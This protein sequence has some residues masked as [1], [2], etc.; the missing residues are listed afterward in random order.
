MRIR[1]LAVSAIAL[2][3]LAVTPVAASNS[4]ASVASSAAQAAAAPSAVPSQQ[5]DGTRG[6]RGSSGQFQQQTAS[7]TGKIHRTVQLAAGP[8]VNTYL[9][10]FVD[11]AVPSYSGGKAGLPATQVESGQRLDTSSSRV[12]NYEQF[13]AAEQDRF[14]GRVETTIGRRPQVRHTYQYAV[15]GMA[16]DLTAEEVLA[17]ANDPNVLS[18]RPNFVRELHSDAGPAWIEAD[19]LW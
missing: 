14:V 7:E 3:T 12:R 5:T 15:N 17:I 9:V 6:G 11:S 8:G 19:Q 16:I 13:L 4:S 2:S 10:R 1:T 18:I